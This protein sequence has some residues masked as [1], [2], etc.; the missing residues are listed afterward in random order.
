VEC[1][2]TEPWAQCRE[3]QVQHGET[4]SWRWLVR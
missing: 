3:A 2:L 4:K 1:P